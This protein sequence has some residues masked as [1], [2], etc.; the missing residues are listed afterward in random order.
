MEIKAKADPERHGRVVS[1]TDS[2]RVSLLTATW[3]IVEAYFETLP[4]LAVELK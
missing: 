1:V 4:D 3:D 2:D